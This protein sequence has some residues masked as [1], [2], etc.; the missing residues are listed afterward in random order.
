MKKYDP[1]E[2]ENKLYKN[3]EEK[4]YFK[5]DNS[6]DKKPFSIVIPPPNVTGSLHMG[7]ALNNTLQDI[8]ARYKR[9][10]G[11][12]VLWLPGCDH[13]G[14]A[15][16]NVVEKELRKQGTSRQT[17][18]RE[19]FVEKVWEWKEKYG[20]TIMSQ[21]RKMGSSPDWSRERFTMDEGLSKAVKE[22]FVRLYEEGLIYRGDYIINWCPRCRTA[23][24]DI[25][26][27]HREIGG[28]FYH[29]KYPYRD[30]GGYI[31]VATTRPETMLG[32]TAVAVHPED[33]RYADIKD[34]EK[35][36]LP[37]TGREIPVIRDEYV[38]REFGTGAVKITPAHDPNDFEIGKKHGL[39][40]INLLNEDGTMNENAGK[41]SKY[42]GMDRFEC[43]KALVK[44]LDGQKLLDKIA[45]H[46]H[47]VGHC[48]RCDTVIE[49][50]VST[51]WF[52][53]IKPLAEPAIKAVEEGK[54]KFVPEMWSKV[55]FEWMKNIRDW[56]ISRQLW[57]GHR[58]PAYYCEKC[59]HM[60]VSKEPVE[61][62]EKC[63]GTEI[64]QDEDVLDTW[65]S[66]GLWPFSTLGWPEETKDLKVFYPTSVL[67]TS[68]DI[69]FFWV[70]RMI[71]NGMK[72][73]GREPFH[74]VVINSLVCDAE[75]KKMSKSKGNVVDPLDV[76][77]NYS[78][79]SLRFTMAALETQQRHIAFSEE[80]LKG[81]HN[82]MNKIWNAAK[83]VIM[84]IEGFEEK[85]ISPEGLR[86]PE[87]WILSEFSKLKKKVT[88]DMEK[89]E[90]SGTALSLYDFFWHVFCDWYLEISK[91]ELYDKKSSY[92]VSVKNVLAKV[93]KES[94][95]MMHTIIPFITEEIYL[96]LP[97]KGKKESI[98]M[99][100]W[101]VTESGFEADTTDMDRIMEVIYHIRNLRGELSVA[102]GAAVKVYCGL[103]D[104][105][106]K[107]AVSEN[108]DFIR[109]LAG[110]ESFD[111]SG[112]YP[113]TVIGKKEGCGFIG[114]DTN[115]VVDISKQAGALRAKI[116]KHKKFNESIEKKLANEKFV[117]NAPEKVVETEKIKAQKNMDIIGK[118]AEILDM[119]EKING[120]K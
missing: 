80:R 111:F 25:E 61:K 92:A 55:Y 110:A 24:S 77:K 62:C 116:D 119:L 97:V 31:Q 29:I 109:P 19:K 57:W 36:L 70:A 51:Q 66:S 41:K 30:R 75:G 12:N 108:L 56:C 105:A 76:M 60:M 113:K 71:M 91:P 59:G 32:D 73:M 47:A 86:L 10:R 85:K 9:A 81:Y 78:A 22:V 117:K 6:S 35:V 103:A 106:A 94:L 42:K 11:Y 54:V 1:K 67:V 90:F 53:K 118:S 20:A 104:E 63:G 16:Q 93:L 95:I 7:H 69:L 88:S 101:P 68:W 49:P 120:V 28:K 13:A 65:F 46:K 48:Y 83:F 23:L 45:G 89:Y 98:M 102:P 50:Y 112:R 44:E 84:N 4:G 64:R 26:V 40:I 33:E 79:D 74:T 17:L 14:I 18:G 115:G 3:W 5:A 34:G 96:N 107:N 37:E 100:S 52:V 82:F 39:E 58:I 38:D 2:I 87:R 43:R 8:L 99:E 15:T 72:F 27:T 114:F 21:L